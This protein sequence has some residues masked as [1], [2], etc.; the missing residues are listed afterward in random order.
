MVKLESFFLESPQP[1]KQA[2]VLLYGYMQYIKRYTGRYSTLEKLVKESKNWGVQDISDYQERN[3][4]EIIH[5]ASTEIPY[6]KKLFFDYGIVPSQIQNPSDLKLLPVLQKETLRSR[7]NEFSSK[8]QKPYITNKTSGST[9]TPTYIH[10]DNR[11]YKLAMALLVDFE[12][13]NN[14]AFKSKKATFAGR[15]IKKPSDLAPPFWVYNHAERQMLYSSYHLN[16]ST[17][18]HY[19]NSLNKFK[20]QEIIGYPSAI[21]ELASLIH[22]SSLNISFNPDIIITNSEN[23]HD[24]QVAT[25]EKVFETSVKDYYSTAEYLNF[26]S[27]DENNIYRSSPLL[28]ITELENIDDHQSELIMTTL[29]NKAMPLIRYNIGD[30]ATVVNHSND[31][32]GCPSFSAIQGRTDD[33]L[34]TEDGRKIGRLSQVFKGIEGLKEAQIVQ[35]KPGSAIINVVGDD[36]LVLDVAE[37]RKNINMRLPNNFRIEI[38]TVKKIPRQKNGKFK[39]VVKENQ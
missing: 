6:Y 19:V 26:S 14:V 27:Q 31:V 22:A 24:W 8:K 17:I 39:L 38:K 9:G 13:R 18:N 37:L 10:L 15:T 4:K 2:V 12:E 25:I 36:K 1:I 29:T 20:P 5:Y 28:G 11:T 3:I 35:S 16:P 32:F 30:I 21:S 23:L 7:A 34:D 33:Y